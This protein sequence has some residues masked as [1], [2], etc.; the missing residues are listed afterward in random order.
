MPMVINKFG[1]DFNNDGLISGGLLINYLASE[2]TLKSSGA[3]FSDASSSTWD[4]TA[5]KNSSGFDVLFEGSM[6]P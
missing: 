2:Y 3:T 1:R 5:A 6:E 4:V